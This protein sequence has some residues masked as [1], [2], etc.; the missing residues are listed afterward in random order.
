MVMP[1]PIPVEP[2]E[3]PVANLLR[4]ERKPDNTVV[5]E[6]FDDKLKKFD[7]TKQFRTVKGT[8]DASGNDA[9]QL[10]VGTD[11]TINDHSFK[12][13]SK[14]LKIICPPEVTK[15]LVSLVA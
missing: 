10:Q 9:V 12:S 8:L 1:T 3:K 14:V 15:Q 7:L 11:G 2:V 13:V 4:I 6:I 5:V